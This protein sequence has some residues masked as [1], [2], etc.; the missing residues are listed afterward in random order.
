MTS[1]SWLRIECATSA[2]S[3]RWWRLRA[4]KIAEES[5][6]LI[7][8]EYQELPAVFDLLEAVKPGAPVLHFQRNETSAGVHR[9]EFN[10]APGGNICSV[11]HV[12]DGDIKKVLKRR[13]IFSKTSMRCHPYS[14]A[15]SSPTPRPRIGS[16][17][18]NW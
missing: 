14:T 11:Y 1:R 15:I 3:L 7:E 10:F 18:V 5:L 6:E 12:E 9:E 4:G 13:R 16:P 2:K 8:V 17:M